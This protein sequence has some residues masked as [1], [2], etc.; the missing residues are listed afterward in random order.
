MKQRETTKNLRQERIK[1]QRRLS[2]NNELIVKV[3]RVR[4][5]R[6]SSAAIRR[7]CP[8]KGFGV[9]HRKIPRVLRQV[10]LRGERCCKEA[11]RDNEKIIVSRPQTVKN[12]CIFRPKML[13]FESILI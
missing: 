11:T 8:F 9:I 3:E 5:V 6:A 2:S 13:Q 4:V 1:R 10:F 7:E 12:H